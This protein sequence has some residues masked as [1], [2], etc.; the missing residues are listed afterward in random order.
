MR[1][2]LKFLHTMA[3]CG[4]IGAFAG[5]AILLAYGPQ[6]T[7]E[8]YADMRRSISALCD[9]LLFPSLAVVLVSGLLAMAVHYPFQTLR[10]VWVKALLGLGMFE[11]TLSLIGRKAHAGAELAIQ[12]AAGEAEPEALASVI[13]TEWQMLIFVSA[14][15]VANI[16]LGVWRPLLAWRQSRQA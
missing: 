13:D 10:W 1:K 16:V 15:A 6:D 9:Y 8:A 5:Y 2:A 7:P 12:V 3:S 4:M 11:G 14:L